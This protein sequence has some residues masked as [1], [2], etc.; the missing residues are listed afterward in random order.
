MVRQASC[1]DTGLAR[2]L[3]LEYIVNKRKK[4]L[5]YK[6]WNFTYEVRHQILEY[7]KRIASVNQERYHTLR[8]LK[9][10]CR[11]LIGTNI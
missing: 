3:E 7:L 6:D 8:D 9:R 4:Y 2:S 10:L 1:K 5:K 11:N